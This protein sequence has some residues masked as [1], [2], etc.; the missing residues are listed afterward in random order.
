MRLLLS[1]ALVTAAMTLASPASAALVNVGS[2]CDTTLP[3]PNA[4]ACAGAF[5]GNLN[6]NA[7]IGDLNA[8]LDQ[9]VGGDFTDVAWSALDP[10]KSFF[11][12]DG[13]M[14]N[15]AATLFGTQIISLHFGDAGSGI[16]NHTILYQFDFGTTG[17]NSV[18]LNQRGW[19]N[20]VLIPGGTPPIPEPGTWAMMLIGF[21]AIG[22]AMRRRRAHLARPLQVV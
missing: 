21:G 17:A 3:D 2:G 11:S 4:T 16:G 19:S 5:A 9:L 6:N 10:T 22:F 7:S 18:D 8:A 1:T 15:F 13:E 12:A 20:A 14:L